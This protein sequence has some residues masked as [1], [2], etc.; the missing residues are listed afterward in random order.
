[1]EFLSLSQDYP[2]NTHQPATIFDPCSY[3]E[4]SV[5]TGCVIK[6]VPAAHE[7][8]PFISMAKQGLHR[9]LQRNSCLQSIDS[10]KC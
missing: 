6:H 1:M 7:E 5:Y 2:Q 9:H 3:D 8:E 4:V 10:I